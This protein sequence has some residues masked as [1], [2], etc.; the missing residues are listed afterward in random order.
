MN[1]PPLNEP[2]LNEPRWDERRPALFLDRD[3]VVNHEIGFLYRPEDVRWVDGIFSLARTALGLGYRLVIVTNQS[4]IA[5]GL[6]TSEQFEALMGWMRARFAAEGAALDGVYH[7]PYHPEGLGEWRREHPDRKPSPGMLLRAANDLGLDLGRS[8]LVGDRGS[9][10]AAAHA[11]GLRQ[12]FLLGGTEA[13]DCRGQA[14]RVDALRAV[15]LWM[16]RMQGAPAAGD[17]RVPRSV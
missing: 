16:L 1:Q 4:G 7:C 17:T 6:Y 2:P 14:V 11:A 13:G 5:R 8:I 9:D 15:E 12:A 3:G 10:V